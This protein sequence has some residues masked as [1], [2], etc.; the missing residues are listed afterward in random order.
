[1]PLPPTLTARSPTQRRRVGFLAAAR[2]LL[3]ITLLALPAASAASQ[4][5]QSLE[6]IRKAVYSFVGEQH[7][8]LDTDFELEIGRLDPRLRLVACEF[9]LST[10]APHPSAR[11][12]HMTVG[13]R[14]DGQRPWT[15]Y[16]PVR[17]H[18]YLE[19]LTVGGTI[20]RGRVLQDDDLRPMR[21][22]LAT[23]PHGYFTDPAAV[24]GM[25]T[26]RAL[27][28]GEIL[29]PN[30][31]AEPQM[32]S[33]GQEVWLTAATGG[34]SVSAKAEALQDGARGA[35]IQ[36]RNL[37]SGRVVEAEVVGPNRVQ[38]AL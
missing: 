13:V 12:G 37:S 1:M 5:H 36:V 17:V 24:V 21:K 10:F 22:S 32:V 14:C 19:V 2:G 16:V 9:P 29:A 25:E 33:R 35:R 4:Q 27:R 26:R 11:P 6:S 34:I 23:L 8:A 28:A 20:P 7:A 30:A 3:A 18:S 15:L 38:A 31:V